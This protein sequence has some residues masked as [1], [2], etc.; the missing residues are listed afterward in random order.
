MPPA[1]N[2]NYNTE[3][4]RR[5]GPNVLP[6]T[7]TLIPHTQ[8]TASFSTNYPQPPSST[9]L[10]SQPTSFVY[11]SNLLTQDYGTN[12][13][14]SNNRGPAPSQPQPGRPTQPPILLLAVH[15][16]ANLSTVHSG[17]VDRPLPEGWGTAPENQTSQL[18]QSQSQQA[19]QNQ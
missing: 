12:S 7:E 1:V 8:Q 3:Q 4:D 18:Q 2:N 16:E 6:S 14:L 10:D 15:R 9:R 13:S 5:T 11:P 17:S 19:N